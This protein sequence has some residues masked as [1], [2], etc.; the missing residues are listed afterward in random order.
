MIQVDVADLLDRTGVSKRVERREAVPEL[1][2]ELSEVP[3]GN[4]VVLDVRVEAVSEGRLLVSGTLSTAVVQS[5]ARCLTRFD[6]SVEAQVREVFVRTPGD[7]EYPIDA[8][9][10]TID[11][12]PMVR[13]A[14]V[15][16]LPFA[17]LCR[18]DCL[19]LCERCGG[20]RNMGECTCP[21]EV[22]DTRW[23][24]LDVIVEQLKEDERG[25][26]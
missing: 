22:P 15:P 23:A 5:C 20:D 7:E 3:D 4:P 16:A 19:G 17:P 26:G 25:T 11:L 9:L 24:A 6:G 13:D 10:G 2:V 12:E 1:K 14:V 21:E 18:P 8:E